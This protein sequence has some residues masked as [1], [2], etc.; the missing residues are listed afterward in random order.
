MQLLY[1]CELV[2]RFLGQ[3]V[4]LLSTIVTSLLP[5]Y[6]HDFSVTNKIKTQVNMKIM[7]T[8]FLL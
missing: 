3:S 7:L 1:H 5:L 6:V 2:V 4:I 8:C